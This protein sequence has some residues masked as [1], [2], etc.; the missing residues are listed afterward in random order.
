MSKFALGL[1]ET[2]GLAAAIEAG[3]TAV[4]SANINLIGY[5][6]S[7]GGGMVTVK[8]EGNVGAVKAAVDA[9]CI[10][11][12]KVSKVWSKQVI[13]RP[14]DELEKLIITK[15]TVGIKDNKESQSVEEKDLGN[16]K[17]KDLYIVK[18]KQEKQEEQKNREISENFQKDNDENKKI[19]EDSTI[20]KEPN[21]TCNLCE[22][23]KCSRQ[24]GEPRK[25]CIHYFK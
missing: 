13:P 16:D 14:H 6:L 18:S 22:D 5:E 19:I 17:S 24:K 21:K 9:G 15:E 4:K 8:I 2:V 25:D 3:D 23:P 12:E 11:A 7:K 10:A 1:I 20:D